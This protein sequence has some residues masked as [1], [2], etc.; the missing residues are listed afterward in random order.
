METER[1]PPS[2]NVYA[3]NRELIFAAATRCRT[4]GKPVV[5]TWPHLTAADANQAFVDW[6]NRHPGTGVSMRLSGVV[7]SPVE[8]TQ[9]ASA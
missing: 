1:D 7:H 4:D 9:S 8:A 3:S 2:P 5:V 6:T